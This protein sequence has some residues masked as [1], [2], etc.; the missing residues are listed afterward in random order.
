MF[1]FELL[2]NFFC[3]MEFDFVFL[4]VVERDGFDIFMCDFGI[5]LIAIGF[6][7]AEFFYRPCEAGCGILSAGKEDE[8]FFHQGSS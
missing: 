3:G 4:A 8:G 6:T 2:R 5:A 7:V 1:D